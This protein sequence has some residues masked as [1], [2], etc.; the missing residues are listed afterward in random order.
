[1][2]DDLLLRILTDP[3]AIADPYPLLAE[4]RETAPVHK[5]GVSDYWV[6]TRYDDCRGALR[7][8]RL[9]NAEPRRPRV[10]AVDAAG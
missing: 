2:S 5:S 9:G 10:E 8:P 7:D 4:L 1:M 3:E 6:L